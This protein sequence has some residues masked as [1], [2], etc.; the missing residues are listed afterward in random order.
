MSWL[1][2]QEAHGGLEIRVAGSVGEGPVQGLDVVKV[3]QA[4]EVLTQDRRRQV[5]FEETLSPNP[6]TT[7]R[8]QAGEVD[9]TD[10]VFAVEKK[11]DP[12][13]QR[14]KID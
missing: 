11:L 1:V 9:V 7:G 10:P 14:R 3:G 4:R 13:V 2:Q 12:G 8:F 5:A 6:S